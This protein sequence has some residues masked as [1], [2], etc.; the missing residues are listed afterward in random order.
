MTHGD[1]KITNILIDEH[2]HPVLIDFDGAK[3]HASK[4]RLKKS[5]HEEIKRFLANFASNP[6]ISNQFKVEFEKWI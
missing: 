1:L 4:A 2:E 5:W 6:A 3:E